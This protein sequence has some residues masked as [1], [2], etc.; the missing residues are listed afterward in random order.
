MPL[1]VVGQMPTG[2]IPCAIIFSMGGI[3]GTEPF[4]RLQQSGFA[5]F[6]LPDQ[7]GDIGNLKFSAVVDASEVC[8]LNSVEPHNVL[9][10]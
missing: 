2:I 10:D 8:P 5:G 4:D 7:A 3:L 1:I 6:I 9:P